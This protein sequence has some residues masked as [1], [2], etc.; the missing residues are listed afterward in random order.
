MVGMSYDFDVALDDFESQVQSV[1]LRAGD[2]FL[3][4]LVQQKIKDRDVSLCPRCNAVFGAE[5]TAI[6]EK[7]RM[8]KELAHREEHACQRQLIQ[9]VEG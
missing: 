4:F 9:R 8:K 7:E 5:A 6:F 2:G 1:Y 3:D